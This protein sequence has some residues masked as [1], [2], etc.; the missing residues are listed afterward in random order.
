MTQLD[1]VL[2]EE[3]SAGKIA[4]L[5]QYINDDNFYEYI[6]L[7]KKNADIKQLAHNNSKFDEFFATHGLSNLNFG[8][9]NSAKD[10]FIKL[11]AENDNI[12]NLIKVIN[13]NGVVSISELKESENIFNYCKNFYEEARILATWVNSKSTSSGLCEILLKFILKD[14]KNNTEG[15]IQ[16]NNLKFIEVKASTIGKNASGGHPCGQ[17]TNNDLKI[18]GAWSIYK[19]LNA[20]LFF[21]K[22]KSSYTEYKYFQNKTGFKEFI[23]L[24]NSNNISIDVVAHSIVN[25]ILFQYNFITSIDTSLSSN[26]SEA[27]KLYASAERF[28]KNKSLDFSTILQLIG[29]I[30]LYLYYKIEKFSYLIF[31]MIDKFGNS[32]N[33]GNYWLIRDCENTLLN[34]DEV[35]NHIKFGVLDSPVSNHGRTGKMFLKA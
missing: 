14:L 8:R 28:L 23:D 9:N 5:E 16:L 13:D 12:D 31:V 10:S 27:K 7:I 4:Q 29:A 32:P 35:S 3:L 30:Q 6:K 21:I 26:P 33:S 24:V 20:N 15:D 22:S 19:Y 18:K 11:F 1:K 25:A 34:F 17:K 2:T